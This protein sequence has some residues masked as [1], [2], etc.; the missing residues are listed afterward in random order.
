MRLYATPTDAW[1]TDAP[2]NAGVLLRAASRTVDALLRGRVYD[3][4]ATTGLPTD[5]DV[6]QALQDATVAIAHELEATGT[7]DAGGTQEWQSVGIGN[8]SLSG[9]QSAAGT[10]TVGGIPVPALALVHLSDIGPVRVW[11]R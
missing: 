8:V 6:A 4:D 7:L 3:V 1:P 2:D 5:A 10:V 9:R 11:S